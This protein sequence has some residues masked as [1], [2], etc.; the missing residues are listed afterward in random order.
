[1]ISILLYSSA[2]ILVVIII[3]YFLSGPKYKG[4]KSDHFNGRKFINPGNIKPKGLMAVF[5]WMFTSKRRPWKEIDE[6]G[7]GA[8]PEAKIQS[9]IR[10]T[11]V[12]HTTFL[13]QLD[14]LN[15]L[16]DPIWSERAS[17]FAWAGPKRMRSPGIKFEDLPQIDIVL[18]SHNH[19]D[20]LDVPTLKKIYLK[21][22]PRFITG[23]GIG[24]FLENIGI[25]T[26]LELDWW[27][28]TIVNKQVQILAV[29]AQ[30]FSGRG[31]FDRDAT[32]WMGFVIKTSR[33]N[34]YFA[35]D[36]GYNETSFKEIGQH[37]SP[38]LLSIIPIGAY[39][40]RWFMG[41]I[42]CSPDEAVRIHLDVKSKQSIGSHFGT[43]PLADE[44]REEP[45]DDLKL[46]LKELNIPQDEFIVLK[47]GTWKEF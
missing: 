46:A 44:G 7:Y 19:Y 29:P 35:A 6:P 4:D 39:Q 14:G 38:V 13:I 41:P 1:M 31:M 26:Y 20:H 37:C 17:P 42:H 27:L 10:V 23:L 2:G 30:H 32:L 34:I 9:A 45:V 22:H 21:F 25:P 5:K 12:N 43:F 3:G 18:L 11:F 15:I 36:T 28:E 8:K 47:E 24:G 33:G 16:T 40:P